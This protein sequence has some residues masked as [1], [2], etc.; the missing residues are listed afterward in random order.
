M[1]HLFLKTTL[2]R[3]NFVVF[4]DNPWYILAM[5]ISVIACILHTTVQINSLLDWFQCTVL[6]TRLIYLFLIAEAVALVVWFWW[7]RK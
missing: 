6:N 1:K 4:K 2:Q 3:C 5:L 7:R